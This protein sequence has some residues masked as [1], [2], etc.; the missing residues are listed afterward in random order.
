MRCGS[1]LAE[2][3]RFCPDCGAEVEATEQ[4]VEERK[5]ATILFADL[6]G[7]TAAADDQDPERTR[8]RLERFYDAMATELE[9]AGGTIE[10]Y[11]GDDVMAAFG[12]PA[13][14]EDHAERALHAAL[15]MQRRMRDV[16]GDEVALRIGVNTGEVVAGRA[17]A[18]AARLSAAMPSTSPRVSRRPLRQVRSSSACARRRWC[19]ER[20]SL[21][22]A[23]RSRRRARQ[24]EWSQPP[25]SAPCR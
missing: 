8:A 12:A 14:L 3:V 5:L 10:K 6:V 24:A 18:R 1:R 17:R 20:S 19:V 7:S 25:F 4:P 15:G 2:N 9:A 11:A 21:A 22:S 16:F 23:G 13:A